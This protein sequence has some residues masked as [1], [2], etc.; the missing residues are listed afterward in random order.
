M[1]RWSRIIRG[2]LGTGLTFSVGVGLVG[3]L[4]AGVVG[5]LT[6]FE[7]ALEMVRMVFASAVWAFP[8]GVAFSGVLSLT[9]RGRSF[10]ELSLP[11]FVALGAGAGLL[12]FGALAL[13]AWDAWSMS[14]AM[15]NAGLFVFLGSGSATATLVL[16]RKAEPARESGGDPPT[17][18]AG[19][20]QPTHR[21]GDEQPTLESIAPASERGEG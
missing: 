5:L 1:A 21:S 12:L 14:T 7:G 18:E 20:E 16:A 11:R 4:V 6:G 19:D 10:D 2:M 3:S 15:V 17:L 9:A 13:N 8:M